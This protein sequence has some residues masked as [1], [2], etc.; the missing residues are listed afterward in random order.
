LLS[1]NALKYLW[2]MPHF[3][4]LTEYRTISTC[5]DEQALD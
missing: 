2:Q 5:R 4:P 1:P 3:H